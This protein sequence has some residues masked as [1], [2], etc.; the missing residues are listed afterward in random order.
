MANMSVN[1]RAQFD[2]VDLRVPT[3]GVQVRDRRPLVAFT[4]ISGA[5][6]AAL[7][8]AT[9]VAVD[10]WAKA[11]VLGVIMLTT[12]GLMIAVSPLRRS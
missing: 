10:G 8:Y 3:T 12:V 9:A 4:L 7:V 11:V 5:I 6:L 1:Q 2:R